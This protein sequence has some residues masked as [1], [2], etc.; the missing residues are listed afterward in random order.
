MA[1][2]STR[3]PSFA[4][5]LNK[6]LNEYPASGSIVVVEATQL[7]PPFFSKP[8]MMYCCI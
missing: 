4:A 6:G 5:M 7:A 3:D 8:Y 2:S 1:K